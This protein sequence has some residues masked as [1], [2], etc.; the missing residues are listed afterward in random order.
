V[1]IPPSGGE[2]PQQLPR[3]RDPV[4]LIGD[5]ILYHGRSELLRDDGEHAGV[6]SALR[7]RPTYRLAVNNGGSSIRA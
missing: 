5:G 1:T 2:L 4:G 3:G 7:G 6:E